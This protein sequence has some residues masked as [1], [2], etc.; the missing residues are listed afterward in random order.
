[1]HVGRV[2]EEY[3]VVDGKFF[4]ALAQLPTKEERKKKR[5]KGGEEAE[6]QEFEKRGR[7][8]ATS[9]NKSYSHPSLHPWPPLPF[10]LK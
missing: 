5:K 8:I 10:S 2:G 3:L 4:V 9:V 1:M 6:N 7:G